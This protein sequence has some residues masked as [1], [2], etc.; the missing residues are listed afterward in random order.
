MNTRP[1]NLSNC[2]STPAY[3]AWVVLTTLCLTI[4]TRTHAQPAADTLEEP[5]P[6]APATAED[7]DPDPA[8][9]DSPSTPTEEP[10][11]PPQASTNLQQ[12]LTDAI[13]AA[14]R[15]GLDSKEKLPPVTLIEN[16]A[17]A[18]EM[19][20]LAPTGAS[21]LLKAAIKPRP[22]KW[23]ISVANKLAA[24][25]SY[26]RSSKAL[27]ITLTPSQTL[28]CLR[29]LRLQAATKD[30]GTLPIDLGSPLN[31]TFALKAKKPNVWTLFDDDKANALLAKLL[32]LFE[33]PAFKDATICESIRF[34]A[35]SELRC[36]TRA[37]NDLP[38][39]MKNLPAGRLVLMRADDDGEAGVVLTR[40]AAG[41][42]DYSRDNDNF[43]VNPQQIAVE[44][45]GV[46]GFPEA[47]WICSQETA[48]KYSIA[49]D[50]TMKRARGFLERQQVRNADVGIQRLLDIAEKGADGLL[51][52]NATKPRAV[53]FEL[54]PPASDEGIVLVDSLIT[55][56]SQ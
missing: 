43:V 14:E 30:N 36:Y 51:T 19:I 13:A 7:T 34:D 5:Q 28:Y 27:E 49:A 52:A 38:A 44:I 24:T 56:D 11:L 12:A 1:H 17:A 40:L 8:P 18:P 54:M 37:S 48:A 55:Q 35:E 41:T 15:L 16:L 10:A 20:T 2:P 32:V 22:G 46:I 31:A 39:Y 50:T 42:A 26:K 33:S 6:A 45:D 47:D 23:E 21:R 9:S 3:L 4:A 25:V 53:R 29:F